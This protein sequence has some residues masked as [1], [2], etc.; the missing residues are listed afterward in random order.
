VPSVH[1]EYN[2]ILAPEGMR[3]FPWL[4]AV[5]GHAP[6]LEVSTSENAER[7]SVEETKDSL[8]RAPGLAARHSRSTW[9]VIRS[10]L[11]LDPKD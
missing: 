11:E 5:G 10:E 6:N 4:F 3:K 1:S 9:R 8:L 2:R 7:L